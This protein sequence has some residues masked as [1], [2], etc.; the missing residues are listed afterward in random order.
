[1]NVFKIVN[2]FLITLK[3]S[4]GTNKKYDAAKKLVLCETLMI[5][6]SNI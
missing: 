6:N 3:I 5:I 1:M 4:L 2:H